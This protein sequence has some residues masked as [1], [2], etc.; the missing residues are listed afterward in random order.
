M[1]EF[2]WYGFSWVILILTVVWLP[3]GF[4]LHESWGWENGFI[5]NL[6]LV[7]LFLGGVATWR[8]SRQYPPGSKIRRLWIW[9]LPFWGLLFF[10]ELSWGRCFYRI[11]PDGTSPVFL[12][13]DELW[14]N[15]IVDPLICLTL[16][17]TII[18][19]IRHFDFQEI[20]KQIRFNV[21]YV[22]VFVVTAM[23][24][25]VIESGELS[26]FAQQG[27]LLEEFGETIAYLCLLGNVVIHLPRFSAN[28]ITLQ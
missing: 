26:V 25:V 8:V 15:P 1:P 27:K 5:E 22:A 13:G 9:T 10:R 11:S 4:F 3:I 7:L 16:I 17:I 19:L 12:P 18:E 14:F 24:V 23:G 21:F 28:S 2:K 6:Q 20:K